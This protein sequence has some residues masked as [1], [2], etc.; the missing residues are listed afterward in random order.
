MV[1][2]NCKSCDGACCKYVAMEV[3]CPENLEDFEN[4]KWYVIHENVQ[5]Y[6]EEDGTWNVEFLT[7]CKYLMEDRKCSI[8]EV[9]AENSEVKRPKICRD[10]T[11]EECPHHN[12]YKE[13]FSFKS[14]QDV[15]EYIE[16]IFKKGLHKIPEDD[17]ED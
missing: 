14:I 12:E 9:F 4:I 8:H 17:D 3:D 15:E 10:F 13:L 2:K 16:K 11:T 7:P 6:V 1:E 5:V